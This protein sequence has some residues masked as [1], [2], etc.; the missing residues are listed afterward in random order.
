LF[1]SL[2]SEV[3]VL[4]GQDVELA[5]ASSLAFRSVMVAREGEAKTGEIALPLAALRD[6]RSVMGAKKGL[7][8]G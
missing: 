4:V 8:C 1:E 7:R 2:R 5:S 3:V 6:H